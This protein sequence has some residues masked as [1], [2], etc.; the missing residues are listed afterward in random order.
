MPSDP[1]QALDPTPR[2]GLLIV[3]EGLDGSGKSS[4]LDGL[5][6][7]LERRGRRV[8]TVAWQPSRLVRRAAADPRSRTTLTARVA[9]L[10]AAADAQ[11]R[12]GARVARRLERGEVVLAD[13]YAWTA[14]A[15][16]V[17]RGLELDWSVDLHR[18]LPAPDLILFHRGEAGSAVERALAARPPSVRSAAVAA[19][20]GSF[21]ERLVAA[22]ETLVDRNRRGAGTPWPTRVLAL[23]A[24][25][26]PA[27]TAVAARDAI[28]PLLELA[29]RAGAR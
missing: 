9:A 26:D 12:I 1:A 11:H 25:A 5:A 17:A 22:F 29:D 3:A 23:D 2:R 16:E 4:T 21:V 10:M 18:T 6:G 7:W 8:R 20:Y 28:R 27:V 13:R 19:A 15:R 24:L 14:I